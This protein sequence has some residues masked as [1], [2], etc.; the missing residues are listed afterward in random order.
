VRAARS[1]Y[2]SPSLVVISPRRAIDVPVSF[3]QLP[4]CFNQVGWA[5]LGQ[6]RHVDPARSERCGGR[7]RCAGHL[8]V[9]HHRPCGACSRS[10]ARITRRRLHEAHRFPTHVTGAWSHDASILRRKRIGGILL[11]DLEVAQ[12]FPGSVRLKNARIPLD[13]LESARG[14]SR[15]IKAEPRFLDRGSPARRHAE[16]DDS[17][18]NDRRALHAL[19]RPRGFEPLTYGSGGRRSIQLSYGRKRSDTSTLGLSSGQQ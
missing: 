7:R 10:E 15:W 16:R 8:P 13:V 3:S 18:E 4:S 14:F 9:S 2:R 12:N 6:R 19:A 5:R 17:G 1:S 11:V